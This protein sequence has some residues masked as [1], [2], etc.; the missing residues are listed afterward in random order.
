M[1]QCVYTSSLIESSICSCQVPLAL[2]VFHSNKSSV[3]P[4]GVSIPGVITPGIIEANP[5]PGS[6][7]E[8]DS[9]P[10]F[11][12]S[13]LSGNGVNFSARGLRCFLFLASPT[14]GMAAHSSSDTCLSSRFKSEN[15]CWIFGLEEIFLH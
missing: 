4:E 8:L 13:T 5:E 12:D 3:L 2:V 10:R 7:D 14:S 11:L 1:Y 15:C 9:P 6:I